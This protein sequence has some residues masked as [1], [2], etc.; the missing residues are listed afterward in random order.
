MAEV[1]SQIS[2]IAFLRRQIRSWLGQYGK[3]SVGLVTWLRQHGEDYQKHLDVAEQR[4]EKMASLAGQASGMVALAV[5]IAF[6]LFLGGT[7]RLTQYAS[8]SRPKD[9]TESDY[10]RL[11]VDAAKDLRGCVETLEAG[12]IDAELLG[13]DRRLDNLRE[14]E[15]PFTQLINEIQKRRVKSGHP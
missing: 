10:D 2:T 7:R 12:G 13:A 11:P 6:V 8:M 9:A 15:D 5:K 4:L 1:D 14:S 3:E